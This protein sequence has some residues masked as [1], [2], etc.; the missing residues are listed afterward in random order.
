MTD[1]TGPG[2]AEPKSGPEQQLSGSAVA[3]PASVPPSAER[4]NDRFADRRQQRRWV[5]ITAGWTVFLVGLADV[6]LGVTAPGSHI[7]HRP[8]RLPVVV[9]G[10]VAT[11]TR[12]ADIIIG[13]LLLMLSHGLRR[14]KHRAWQ[15]VMAL[16][17]ISGLVIL[18]HAI[19]LLH[20]AGMA[21]CIGIAFTV[22]LVLI[23]AWYL[24]RR[25]F[26]AIGDPRTRWRALGA[27]TWLLAADLVIGLSYIA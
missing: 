8:Q 2:P 21:L 10:T 14:R 4:P 5:P 12:P 26:Y 3:K 25:E 15:E 19:D 7:H 24:T 23:P 11:L 6:I 13:L 17:V 20:R 22:I 1:Q 9:P 18:A 16:L 27:F